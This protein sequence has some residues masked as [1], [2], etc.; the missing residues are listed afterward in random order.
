[1]LTDVV[2]GED[3]ISNAIDRQRGVISVMVAYS[4]LDQILSGLGRGTCREV[5]TWKDGS[6]PA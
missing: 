4:G 5:F 2:V 6:L 3:N 1:M